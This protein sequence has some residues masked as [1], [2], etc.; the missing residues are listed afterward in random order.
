M[1]SC[2]ANTSQIMILGTYHMDNAGLDTY[3]TKA[4]DVLT[5]RRQKEI[6]Q[7]LDKLERYQPTKIAIEG[8]YNEDYWTKRYHDYLAGNYRL[9]RNEVEQIGFKLAQRLHHTDIYP[10]DY[11]MWMDGRVPAEIA[12]PVMKPK[13]SPPSNEPPEPT[14]D[15]IRRAEQLFK[16]STVFEYLRYLNSDAAR[17]PDH[18]S[19]FDL[20]L[21]TDGNA[22]YRR[23]DLLTNWYKRNLRIFTNIDRITKFPG[24]RILLMIGSEHLTI[25]SDFAKSSNYFCLVDVEDYLK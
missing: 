3:N 23:T 10:V 25:L 13:P 6:D 4:D 12:D 9:G 8:Q 24:D 15:W 5:E 19:S 21:P 11:Q 20:L 16:T 7:V 2:A 22:P 18:S 1:S 14:P 17:R